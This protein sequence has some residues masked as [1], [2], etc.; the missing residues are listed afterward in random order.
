MPVSQK[1]ENRYLPVLNPNKE[2]NPEGGVWMKVQIWIPHLVSALWFWTSSGSIQMIFF[3]PK[4][5]VK[6]YYTC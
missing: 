2:L 3:T 1:T 5:R 4:S 6:H